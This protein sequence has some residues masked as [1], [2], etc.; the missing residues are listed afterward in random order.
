MVEERYGDQIDLVDVVIKELEV[1]K[2]K[3][4]QDDQ[5]FIDLVDFRLVRIADNLDI[6]N[7][8]PIFCGK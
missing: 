7:N 8:N 3:E 2:M 5:K 1:S 6:L 4:I